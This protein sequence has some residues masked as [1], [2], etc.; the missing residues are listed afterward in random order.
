MISRGRMR[1]PIAFA[2][3]ATAAVAIGV[4][5]ARALIGGG[6]VPAT[7]AVSLDDELVKTAM[8][9]ELDGAVV[10]GKR[11]YTLRISLQLTD[12]AAPA[13]AFQ[14][15]QTFT[16]A[17]VDLLAGN[18]T[19]ARAYTLTNASVVAYRQTAAA[20]TNALTQELVLRSRTLT[21]G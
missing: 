1:F 17:R 11:E 9:Y 12:N 5:G 7:F 14:T 6:T 4:S 19:T 8:G 16:T 21:V 15:G 2:L 10:S 20:A 18:F 13:Q 3:A